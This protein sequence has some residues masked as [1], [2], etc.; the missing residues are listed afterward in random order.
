M[1]ERGDLVAEARGFIEG[2]DPTS[3]RATLI[4]DLVDALVHAEGM[5]QEWIKVA[6]AGQPTGGDLFAVID[7]HMPLSDGEYCACGATWGAAHLVAA[8]TGDREEFGVFEPGAF[9]CTLK[10]GWKVKRVEEAR[11]HY[12]YGVNSGTLETLNTPKY[13][14]AA[15][16]QHERRTMGP[17]GAGLVE[18]RTKITSTSPWVAKS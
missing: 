9:R 8:L 14:A 7:R 1:N 11:I 2:S 18:T 4:R 15:I 16:E 3:A 5:C 12:R 6:E 10:G 13:I 17:I